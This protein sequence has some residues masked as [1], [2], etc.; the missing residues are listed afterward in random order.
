MPC[1]CSTCPDGLF[2]TWVIWRHSSP[3]MPVLLA[4]VTKKD[5]AAPD[6]FGAAAAAQ[7]KHITWLAAGLCAICNVMLPQSAF[8]CKGQR[9]G[10]FVEKWN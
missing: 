4:F 7:H 8:R 3:R 9:E 6:T 10:D 5:S 2:M 1:L